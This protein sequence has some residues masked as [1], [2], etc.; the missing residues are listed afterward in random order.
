VKA[1]IEAIKGFCQFQEC[2]SVFLQEVYPTHLGQSL[3][4]ALTLSM[5]DTP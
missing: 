5:G 4:S 1:F 2:D 3:R